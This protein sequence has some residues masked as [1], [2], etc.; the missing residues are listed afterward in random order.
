V[1]PTNTNTPTPTV[2]VTTPTNTVKPTLTP[3]PTMTVAVTVMPTSLPT[4]TAAATRVPTVTKGAVVTEKPVPTQIGK[5]TPTPLPNY[6]FEDVDTTPYPTSSEYKTY[7]PTNTPAEGIWFVGTATP[8]GG[9]ATGTKSGRVYATYEPEVTE[10]PSETVTAAATSAGV[11]TAQAGTTAAPT[12]ASGNTLAPSQAPDNTGS[13][14]V[15]KIGDLVKVSATTYRILSE[16]EVSFV[17]TG[18]ENKKITIP[19]K[20]TILDSAYKIIAI[21][22]EAFKGNK[23]LEQI[24][25]GKNIVSIG[26]SAFENCSKLKKVKGMSG[27]KEIGNNVFAKCKKLKSFTLTK[28]VAKIGKTVFNGDKKLAVLTVKS[29]KLEKKTVAKTAFKGMKK[30]VVFKIK[31]KKF[32]KYKGI[33]KKLKLSKGS[34]LVSVK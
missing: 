12:L 27:L 32:K 17:R 26:D 9:S 1:K 28:N 33:F 30:N 7:G 8:T 10:A 29:L 23:K 15:I 18:L 6:Y 11:Q 13:G 20:V 25:I 14:P 3:L 2:K 22:A 16:D 19:D 5:G 24:T 4:L 31:K 21:E 34:K